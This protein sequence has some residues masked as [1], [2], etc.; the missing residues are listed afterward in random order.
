MFDFEK[1]YK[2]YE[3]LI[4]RVKQVNEFWMNSVFYSVK[5]FFNIVKAK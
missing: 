4:E 3:E 1:S 5:E 2:Q